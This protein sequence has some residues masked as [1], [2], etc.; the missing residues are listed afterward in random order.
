[1]KTINYGSTFVELMPG[2]GVPLANNTYEY[3]QSL[4]Q[5]VHDNY[6]PNS[7]EVIVLTLMTFSKYGKFSK[8]N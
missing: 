4:S 1:M 5:L 3:Y 2:I 6:Q 8:K 7:F